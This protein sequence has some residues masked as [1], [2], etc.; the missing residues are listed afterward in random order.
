MNYTFAQ[1][2]TELVATQHYPAFNE[3]T[4]VND[5]HFVFVH[6]KELYSL[7]IDS[8]LNFSYY[9]EDIPFSD[10]FKISTTDFDLDGDKDLIVYRAVAKKNQL[11]LYEMGNFVTISESLNSGSEHELFIQ[12]YD[13]DGIDDYYSNGRI[14]K[15]V[16]NGFEKI[17]ELPINMI[18]LDFRFVYFT[19]FDGDGD[20]DLFTQIAQNS[21]AMLELK[22]NG[23][24]ER[25]NIDD[26]NVSLNTTFVLN[27][28]GEELLCYQDK[29]TDEVKRIVWDGSS[30]SAETIAT[31]M[32]KFIWYEC[33]D[34]D[35]DTEIEIIY[36]SGGFMNILDYDTASGEFIEYQVEKEWASSDFCSWSREDNN[37]LMLLSKTGVQTI[38]YENES[39]ILN[40]KERLN[41]SRGRYLDFDGDGY[42]DIFTTNFNDGS[43]LQ[44]FLGN[45]TFDDVIA[46]INITGTA[47][48]FDKDGDGDLDVILDQDYAWYENMGNLE[49]S[50]RQEL[51]EWI[52]PYPEYQPPFTKIVYWNDFNGDGY[53]EIITYNEFGEDL[54]LAVNVDGEIDGEILLAQSDKVN[55]DLNFIEGVD[56]DLDGDMDLVMST[57]NGTHWFEQIGN[58]EFEYHL[59]YKEFWP[60]YA[61]VDDINMDGFPDLLVGSA[62]LSGA[63]SVGDLRIYYGTAD[64]P[65]SDPFI[66]DEAYGV[67]GAAFADI[68]GDE[69][70][71]IIFLK[72]DLVAWLSFQ[73]E[74][75]YKLTEI[76]NGT[77]INN[78]LLVQDLDS[79]G[80]LDFI[81]QC[82][83]CFSDQADQDQRVSYYINS[84]DYLSSDKSLSHSKIQS[85]FPNPA[86]Q[87]IKWESSIANNE[88]LTYEIYS[89]VASLVHKGDMNLGESIN[90][91]GLKNGMYFLKV[92]DRK[93]RTLLDTASF[94]VQR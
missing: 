7:L 43:R 84:G 91:Q 74:E 54:I 24:Y 32:G 20:M 21:L 39:Y 53:N 35:G 70:P 25:R 6:E 88:S 37:Q 27:T 10:V 76:D 82:G 79:D 65:Q 94:I 36:R 31:P 30:F 67:D 85:I 52:L 73:S 33:M 55:A 17:K 69:R 2:E 41:I 56:M 64:G 11:L 51:E 8:D 86:T 14:Y 9:K 81:T 12:D 1:F 90:I 34:I 23:E 87:Y 16:N 60:L 78:R 57:D 19:D 89:A 5:N 29:D 13:G 62:E 44:R 15:R 47:R 45:R 42:T 80:D 61:D 22:D 93:T 3:L 75:S 18:N 38:E 4:H 26:F 77:G 92:M 40:F 71:E 48:F 50:G 58:L 83:Q 49:F 66:I 68:V 28:N 46:G 63:M 72:K 59:I